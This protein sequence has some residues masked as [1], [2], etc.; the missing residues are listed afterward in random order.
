[1]NLLARQREAPVGRRARGR[2][3]RRVLEKINSRSRE[4]ATSL[5]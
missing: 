1:M 2:V 3:Q 5:L 4:T